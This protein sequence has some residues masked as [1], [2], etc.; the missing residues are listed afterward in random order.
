MIVG[1]ADSWA[2]A[3]QVWGALRHDATVLVRGGLPELRAL[4]RD[5]TLPPLNDPGDERV[6]RVEPGGRPARFRLACTEFD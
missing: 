1:D 6:W 5:R 4:V 2:A 3:W